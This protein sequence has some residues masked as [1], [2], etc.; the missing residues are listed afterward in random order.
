MNKTQRDANNEETND[1]NNYFNFSNVFE[2]GRNV[3]DKL[4]VSY[5][6]ACMAIQ[7]TISDST[8]FDSEERVDAKRK[9]KK[10]V[11][12]ISD[13]NK[14]V[15]AVSEAKAHRDYSFKNEFETMNISGSRINPDSRI[16]LDS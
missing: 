14:Q 7:S 5:K 12:V 4:D 1:V 3:L 2:C 10:R 11:D 13:S 8:I 9:S 16:N 6:R 15:E